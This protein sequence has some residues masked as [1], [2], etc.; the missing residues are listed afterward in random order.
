MRTRQQA[1]KMIAKE[2]S[3]CGEKERRQA[4][5]KVGSRVK[6]HMSTT[7]PVPLHPVVYKH[8]IEHIA[9]VTLND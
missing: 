7:L 9:G 3:F 6:S 2:F 5:G 8:P 1:N 4:A